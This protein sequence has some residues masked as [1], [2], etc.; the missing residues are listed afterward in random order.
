RG[1]TPVPGHPNYP[2]PGQRPLTTLHAWAVSDVAPDGSGEARFFGGTPGGDNQM[3]WNCQTIGQIVAGVDDPGLLVCS[4]RWEWLP[5]DDGVRVEDGFAD[6][7]VAAL[8]AAAPRLVR[9]ERWG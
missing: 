2:S 3:P 1:F 6:D 7:D 4:P 8:A 5:A 9:T